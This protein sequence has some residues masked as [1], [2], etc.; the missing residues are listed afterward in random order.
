MSEN[1]QHIQNQAIEIFYKLDFWDCNTTKE[2]GAILRECWQYSRSGNLLLEAMFKEEVSEEHL[3]WIV[4]L[5]GFLT[6]RETWYT[7]RARTKP[8]LAYRGCHKVEAAGK[9]FGYSWTLDKEVAEFFARFAPDGN[10]V[11]ITGRLTR[12]DAWL[13]TPESEIICYGGQPDDFTVSAPILDEQPQMQ[14]ESRIH[15][16]PPTR[17][18]LIVELNI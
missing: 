18:S 17:S 3:P 11:V 2:D 15:M 14:W 4:T 5:D 6:K 1:N 16:R 8:I 9:E 10:G 7:N 12:I 13:D